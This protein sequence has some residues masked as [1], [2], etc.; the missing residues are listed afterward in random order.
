LG[1]QLWPGDHGAQ[2]HEGYP[3]CRHR[4]G[5]TWPR[6]DPEAWREDRRRERLPVPYVHVVLPL[7]QELRELV[8][9]HQNDLD[10]LWLRAAA[11]ALRTLAAEPHDVGGLLGVLGVR[12]TWPRPLAYQPHGPGL[13]PAGGVAADH[14]A[15]RPARPTSLVPVQALAKLVRGRGRPLVQ[16]ERPDR[17]MPESV[18]TSGGGVSGQPTRPGAEPVLQ[19]LGRSRHR[20]ALTTSRLLAIAD[21]HVCCRA[22]EAQD[23]RGKTMTL[24]AHECIRRL[25]PQVLPPGGHQV[26][27]DG[28]WSPVHRPLLPH[29]QLWLAA[30]HP[31]VS[32]EPPDRERQSAGSTYV[33]LQAAQLC[34]PGGQGVLAVIRQRPRPQRGPPCATEP[35][36]GLPMPASSGPRRP[37]PGASSHPS[38]LLPATMAGDRRPPPLAALGSP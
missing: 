36:G 8:R 12:H 11:H 7:P 10:D 27:A 2:E 16:Q 29:L 25:L 34:P 33:P 5:P 9:R 21:G 26:R 38:P 23:Q 3:S 1:G 22:Q 28:L 17:P 35:P 24:P 6:L 32:P 37:T 15:W 30:P 19:D 18:W 31:A 13:V 14:P 20:M 4:R